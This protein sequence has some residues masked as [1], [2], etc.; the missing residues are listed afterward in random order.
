MCLADMA[1][2]TKRRT[3]RTAMTITLQPFMAF[4]F[5][6]QL[7]LINYAKLEKSSMR[8]MDSGI[9]RTMKKMNI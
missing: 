1:A 4:S 5:S 3:R 2:G 9:N 7:R 6:E 8:S